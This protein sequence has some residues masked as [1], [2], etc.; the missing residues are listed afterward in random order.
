M[1][2]QLIFAYNSHKNKKCR[3][4]Q[5]LVLY[6]LATRKSEFRFFDFSAFFRYFFGRISVNFLQ[7]FGR[8]FAKKNTGNF[9]ICHFLADN[10]H[11]VNFQ[12]FF[13]QSFGTYLERKKYLADFWNL[14]FV[15]LLNFGT[16][17]GGKS[18][19]KIG[20]RIHV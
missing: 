7:L 3:C 11:L 18:A 16:I 15:F 9:G 8:Y 6:A 2:T 10:L 4:H 19:E 12:H 17:F 1:S 5:I 14:F 20:I 13:W